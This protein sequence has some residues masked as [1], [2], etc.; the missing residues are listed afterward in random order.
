[1]VSIGQNIS[2]VRD[3]IL[4]TKRIFANCIG[5][6]NIVSL[7]FAFSIK[8]ELLVG[9]LGSLTSKSMSNEPPD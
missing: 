8:D 4:K 1:M 9:I 7:L 3:F 2:K 5:C 6:K